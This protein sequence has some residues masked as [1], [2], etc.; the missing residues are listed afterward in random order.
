[1]SSDDCTARTRPGIF[2]RPGIDMEQMLDIPSV[3]RSRLRAW[4]NKTEFQMITFQVND[5]TCGHCVASVTKAVKGLDAAA[6][7]TIDLAA[8]KVAVESAEPTER[9]AHAI[10]EA[11]YTPEV[12]C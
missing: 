2:P 8:H 9:I 1:M 6:Q 11:G 7:V 10:R 4:F 3:G 12:A 5:M